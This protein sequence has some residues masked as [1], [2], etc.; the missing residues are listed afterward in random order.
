MEK[1]IRENMVPGEKALVVCKKKLITE[2]HAPTWSPSDPR[3]DDPK[4]YM[5][6]FQWDMDGRK[7]SVTHYGS[8]IGCNDWKDADVVFLFDEF[9]L[10]RRVAAAT[11]QAL[12]SQKADQGDLGSMKT[13]SS[14]APGVDC[15][16]NGHSLRQIVQMGL[17]GK[18]RFYDEHGV[19]GRQRLV[20]SCNL[21]RFSVFIHKLFPGAKIRTADDALATATL[22]TKLLEFLRTSKETKVTSKQIKNCLGRPWRAVSAQVL[23]QYLTVI[24][25]DLGW[26]YVKGLGRAGSYFMKTQTGLTI[27]SVVRVF[28]TGGI[29][30]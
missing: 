24:E 9:F 2:R 26:K 12:R 28:E 14:K 15:I 29:L 1:I 11:N 30:I 25:D 4:N 22:G 20:I 13:M 6:G 5:E 10:P 8:G 18:A 17:R 23:K 19:C 21:K 16:A 27:M 3:F 7:L